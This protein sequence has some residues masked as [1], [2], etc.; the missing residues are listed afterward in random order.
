[1]CLFG[2]LQVFTHQSEIQC[3]GS[4]FIESGS[5]QK[6]R[7]RIQAISYHYLKFFCLL[8]HNHKIFSSKEVNSK[9]DVVKVTNNNNLLVTS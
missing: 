7:I 4:I 2:P 6:Y 8:L 3:F 5:S 1:M 9:T